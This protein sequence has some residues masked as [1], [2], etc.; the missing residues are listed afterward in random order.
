MTLLP[1]GAA[2]VDAGWQAKISRSGGHGIEAGICQWRGLAPGR[3]G[4]ARCPACACRPLIAKAF[5]A[6]LQG[7]CHE[8]GL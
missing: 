1:V 4:L 8:T 3:I 7:I 6:R 2:P 5:R